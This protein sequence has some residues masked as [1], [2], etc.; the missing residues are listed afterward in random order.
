MKDFFEA[1]FKGCPQ[2]QKILIWTL[3]RNGV[4]TSRWGG[5]PDEAASIAQT[6]VDR[7]T[8]VYFGVGTRRQG[9]H[10]TEHERGKAKDV[11]AL[12]AAWLDIDVQSEAHA[13]QNLPETIE[14][15]MTILE[16]IPLDPSIIISSGHGLQAYWLFT[17][18]VSVSPMTAD[19]V[20]Q[21]MRRFNYTFKKFA[22]RSGWDVDSTFDLPRVMRVPG[23]FN[24]KSGTEDVTVLEMHPERRYDPADIE[25]YLIAE[26]TLPP[27]SAPKPAMGETIVDPNAMYPVEKFDA[28]CENHP[29]FSD[30]WFH[31]RPPSGSDDSMSSYD[32]SLASIAATAAWTQQEIVD[33]LVHHRRK[34][35]ELDTGNKETRV[36]Y[37]RRTAARALQDNASRRAVDHIVTV[38]VKERRE[39]E[40]ET[41]AGTDERVKVFLGIS[42]ALNLDIRGLTKYAGDEPVFRI[43]IGEGSYDLGGIENITSWGKFQNKIA[44]HVGKSLPKMKTDAW[45]R[46]WE[47]MLGAATVESI[48]DG[49]NMREIYRAKM[50][51]WMENNTVVPASAEVEMYDGQVVYQLADKLYFSLE[52]FYR[53]VR[54]HDHDNIQRAALAR[55]MKMFGAKPKHISTTRRIEEEDGEVDRKSSSRNVWV[56]STRDVR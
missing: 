38:E 16:A 24:C 39:N 23:S 52:D 50:A 30:R 1:F 15:G 5:S 2:N 48:A 44:S 33:L 17:G 54:M 12:Y 40:P 3:G 28:L 20:T 11:G 31:R 49:G 42:K 41:A 51:R 9:P 26:D 18:P 22:Q 4:K 25:E 13:K 7:D 29:D 32:M 56:V 55:C 47:A 6:A 19:G 46:V 45:A 37:L 8:N 10:I 53:W 43:Q 34:Y 36:D 21:W 14:E 27:M 35:K